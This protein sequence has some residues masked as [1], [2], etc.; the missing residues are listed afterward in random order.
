MSAQRKGIVPRLTKETA[1]T[2][3]SIV[4]GEAM[5]SDELDSVAGGITIVSGLQHQFTSALERVAL[6]PRP[7]PPRIFSFGH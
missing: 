4:K 1:M 7:L 3:L 2:D 6:N 5:T